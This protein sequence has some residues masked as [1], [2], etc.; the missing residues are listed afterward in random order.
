MCNTADGWHC[1][2]L[3]WKKRKG[4][5]AGGRVLDLPKTLQVLTWC[6]RRRSIEKKNTGTGKTGGHRPHLQQAHYKLHIS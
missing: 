4:V 2:D 3:Q 6:N 5:Q 1:V